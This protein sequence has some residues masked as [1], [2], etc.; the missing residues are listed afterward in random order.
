M[1]VATR[2]ET[3]RLEETLIQGWKMPALLL[4]ERAA[5]GVAQVVQSLAPSEVTA[6]VGPGNNGADALAACRLLM[7]QGIPCKAFRIAKKETPQGTLQREWLAEYGLDVAPFNPEI[8]AKGVII[9]GLFGFGLTRAP[10]GAFA[11]AIEWANRQNATVVAVDLPSGLDADTGVSL[12]PCI[13]AHHTVACGV[14]KVGLFCDPALPYIGDLHLA[15]IG[16]PPIFLETLKGRLAPKPAIPSRPRGAH[17]GS[18]GTLLVVAGSRR[19]AGAAQMAITA[20]VRSGAGLVYAA[21][22]QSILDR[23]QVP[24]AILVGMPETPDGYLDDSPALKEL[25]ARSKAILAGPGLGP[26]EATDRVLARLCQSSL[27]LVLDAGALSPQLPRREAPTLLLPHPGEGARLLGEASID[28]QSNRLDS[29]KALADSYGAH[30]I[31]KGARSVLTDGDRYEILAETSPLLATA[32]SG[33][34][35]AGLI[36]GFLAQGMSIWQAAST[37]M[38]L[39]GRMGLMAEAEGRHSLPAMEIQDYFEKALR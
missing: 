8:E 18:M 1:Y 13:R 20:A 35:L 19:Y 21:V 4:M 23:L 25:L 10:E 27:P 30:V 6:L 16:F 29:G 34:V 22:P 28:V 24:E 14:Y 12:G 7:N 15:D 36:G 39:H 5:L 33:D 9:D 31:L 37:G 38:A 17:K 3:V 32:G 26:V 2:E 11:E